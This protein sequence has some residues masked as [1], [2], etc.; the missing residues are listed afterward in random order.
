MQSKSIILKKSLFCSS[1]VWSPFE[2][3][4]FWQKVSLYCPSLF[5]SIPQSISS[6]YFCDLFRSINYYLFH[7]AVCMCAC[8]SQTE[9]DWN[10]CFNLYFFHLYAFLRRLGKPTTERHCEEVRP[11]TPD[12]FLF[13]N[14]VHRTCFCVAWEVTSSCLKVT[15]WL[16]FSGSWVMKYWFIHIVDFLYYKALCSDFILSK[17]YC[18]APLP[19]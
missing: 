16:T 5:S 17:I 8:A 4:L 13:I 3:T 2:T 12:L 6:F 18:T 14:K 9:T 1:F 10:E 7:F 19:M 15:L 11:L